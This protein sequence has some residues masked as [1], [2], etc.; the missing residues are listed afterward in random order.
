MIEDPLSVF[1]I[2][3]TLIINIGEEID[4]RT[5]EIEK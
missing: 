5:T 2:D 4:K 3:N 1:K